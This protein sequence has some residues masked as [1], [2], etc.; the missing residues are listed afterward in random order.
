MTRPQKPEV[1]R[2]S[3]LKRLKR[4]EGQIGIHRF[5]AK[6]AVILHTLYDMYPYRM[7]SKEISKRVDILCQSPR[8]LGM[9]NKQVSGLIRSFLNLE[10]PI[11]DFKY[12]VKYGVRT[13]QLTLTEYGYL[14]MDWFLNGG[15]QPTTPGEEKN[16]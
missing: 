5:V 15:E 9:D 10:P 1:S 8:R 14:M 11:V 13:S 4:I 12:H 16:G 6:R 3:I 2:E 7:N